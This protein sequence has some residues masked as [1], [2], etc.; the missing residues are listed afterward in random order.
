MIP[1]W[2]PIVVP[3][4]GAALLAALPRRP[5]AVGPVVAAA[6]LAAAA[7]LVFGGDA[8]RLDALA[9]ALLLAGAVSSLLAVVAEVGSARRG[10]AAEQGRLV[11]AGFPLLQGAQA[12]ALVAADAAVAW[13]G[14]AWAPAPAPRWCRSPAG[15][16]A[17]PP[18]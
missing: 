9:A 14:L 15:A 13:I 7:A 8:G 2:L 1:T 18:D 10:A 6:S 5:L 4:T 3:W 17:S 16:A 12:L 11:A